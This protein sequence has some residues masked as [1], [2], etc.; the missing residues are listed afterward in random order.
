MHL[1]GEQVGVERYWLSNTTCLGPFAAALRQAIG[2]HRGPTSGQAA[3][4]RGGMA[5]DRVAAVA[6]VHLRARSW[7]GLGLCL[8][9]DRRVVGDGFVGG[10][11]VGG[12]GP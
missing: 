7:L 3:A 9:F 1:S 6:V 8:D 11:L 5:L 2:H 10:A 4:V 12:P